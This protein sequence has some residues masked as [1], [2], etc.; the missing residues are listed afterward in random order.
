LGAV[1]HL[2]I[3]QIGLFVLAITALTAAD[4]SGCVGRAV[5]RRASSQHRANSRI[6]ARGQRRL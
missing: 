2:A 1:R 3:T 5:D 6:A 4:M